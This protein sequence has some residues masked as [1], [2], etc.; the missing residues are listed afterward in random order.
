M[1][2]KHLFFIILLSIFISKSFSQNNSDVELLLINHD[3]V[4]VDKSQN[5]KLYGSYKMVFTNSKDFWRPG[6]RIHLKNNGELTAGSMPLCGT[7]P[8]IWSSLK[9]YWEILKD[10]R[11][12]L[13]Y[14]ENEIH[15]MNMEPLQENKEVEFK[16][17]KEVYELTIINDQYI[18]LNLIKDC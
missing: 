9:G 13:H 17:R 1:K 8:Q 11:I 4:L 18:G 14:T 3:W 15:Y 12:V 6:H 5:K 7:G 2:I 10:N 16:P